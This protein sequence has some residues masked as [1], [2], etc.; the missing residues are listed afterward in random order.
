MV[1]TLILVGMVVAG[2]VAWLAWAVG[3][4][5]AT[6]GLGDVAVLAARLEGAAGVGSGASATA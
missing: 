5:P 3:R 6:A 2:A 1:V 4:K